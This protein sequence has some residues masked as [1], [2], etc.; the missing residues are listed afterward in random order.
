MP[1]ECQQAIRAQRIVIVEVFVAQGYPAHPL[2]DQFQHRVL[3]LV[4]IAIIGEAARNSPH[5]I[6]TVIHLAQQDGATIGGEPTRVE[7]A[8]DLTPTEG[9]KFEW[10]GCTLCTHGTSLS[11]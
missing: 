11:V 2:G 9:V 6:Q 10:R 5:Q 4:G 1:L 7:T 8:Y 3:D